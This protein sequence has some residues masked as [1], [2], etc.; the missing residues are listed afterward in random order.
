L[1]A[2]G[3]ETAGSSRTL[4]GLN[5]AQGALLGEGAARCHWSHG[6]ITVRLSED[7]RLVTASEDGGVR[8][9]DVGAA[10]G[11]A[12]ALV[13]SKG[14]FSTRKVAHTGDCSNLYKR[15]PRVWLWDMGACDACRFGMGKEILMFW[16]SH[17]PHTVLTCLEIYI[18]SVTSTVHWSDLSRG[19][20]VAGSS[21]NFVKPLLEHC[22]WPPRV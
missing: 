14:K 9:W 5:R 2:A 1:L 6:F 4:E 17:I 18:W 21:H 15:D 12:C 8:L 3:S 19:D 11:D 10:K 16:K 7:W 20:L 22:C 13:E